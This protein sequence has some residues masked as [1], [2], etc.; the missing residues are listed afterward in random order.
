[1]F[2]STISVNKPPPGSANFLL[3]RIAHPPAEFTATE[4]RNF[5]SPH[6]LGKPIQQFTFVVQNK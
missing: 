5:F 1:M 3:L 4:A 2:P 6:N